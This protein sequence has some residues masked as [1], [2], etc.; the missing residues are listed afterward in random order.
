[1]GIVS[2]SPRRRGGFAVAAVLLAMIGLVTTRPAAAGY[3]AIVIDASN[4]EVLTEVNADE[5][6]HPASLTKMMT[7]Y[8]AFEAIEKGK[9]GWEQELRVSTWASEKSPTKLVL[10]PGSTISVRDCVLGMIVLSANDAATVMAEAL[11]GTEDSFAH[12]MT[13]KAHELGMTSTSFV[14]ASGLPDEDQVTTARDLVK[15]A[16][17]L[18]DRFPAEYHY[19]STREFQFHGR[20]I[21]GHNRLMYRYAGMDGLKTGYTGASGFNLASSAERDGRRLYGVVMGGMSAPARDKLMATLL[22][23]GFEHRSTDPTLVAM[24]GGQSTRTAHRL[25]AGAERVVAALSPV[26]K[27]EAAPLVMRGSSSAHA[28]HVVNA[29]PA[30]A[31]PAAGWSVQVGAYSKHTQA[32]QAAHHAIQLAGLGSHPAEVVAPPPKGERVYRARLG[33]FTSEKQARDA[34]TALHR[35]GELCVVVPPVKNGVRLAGTRD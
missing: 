20:T 8:L 3:A 14:N 2:L 18:H 26:S 33:D 31:A 4:G 16:M 13:A 25:L 32:E 7:L 34:C 19:F 9:L 29:A 28:S 21:M 10:E 5:V 1:M 27:A 22:D 24:A 6:N 23:D 30:P 35:K 15:L 11:G 12:M 17:A